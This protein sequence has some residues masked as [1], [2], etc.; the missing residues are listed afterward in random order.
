M[1]IDAKPSLTE[2]LK[3]DAAAGVEANATKPDLTEMLKPGG[4]FARASL[5]HCVKCTICETQCPVAEAT[6]LF[7][8]PKFVGPQAERYRHGLSIDKSL[9]YCSQCGTCTLVCPQGV[10]IAEINAN[11]Q[12]AMKNGHVSL[13]DRLISNTTMMGMM[14]TPV[15]P[16]ANAALKVGVVRSLMHATIGVHKK[17][18]MPKAHTQTFMGW[19]KKHQRKIAKEGRAV[20]A[21][22][23][24]IIFFHG[25]AGGYFEVETS[26]MTVKVLEHI[27]YE[28]IVPPQGCCG[29]AQKSN[30]LFDEATKA[31]LKLCDQLRAAGKELTIVSSSGSCTGMLKHEAHEIIGVEDER[32]H[33]VGTRVRDIFEFLLE[34]ADAGELPLDFKTLDM[35]VPYHQPCQSKAQGMGAPAV[36]VLRLI[37]GLKVVES[38]RSCCGMAGTYGIKK[39]KFD[40]A[41]AVAKPLVKMIHETNPDLALCDTEPCRW[42]IREAAKV[43]TE[44]PIYL[45]Y[46]AY[47]LD[48]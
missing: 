12:V 4:Q 10:K 2:M 33:D 26:K 22:R 21:T 27:G 37:P 11:A 38:G 15:A 19:W 13:R 20:P 31:V 39:E 48:N 17:A 40:I 47:G 6:P 45:M 7:P 44:H 42:Q 23:G 30:A 3:R 36:E 41:Q 29:L 8:G 46:L 24:P 34:L 14:M 18:P 28:V 35:T 43:R 5:D 1:T 32:L 16:I 25:C 9:D